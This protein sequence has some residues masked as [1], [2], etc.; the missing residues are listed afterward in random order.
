MNAELER[1]KTQYIFKVTHMLACLEV[2]AMYHNFLCC[3]NMSSKR[4]T[5]RPHGLLE[6]NAI[7]GVP[8]RL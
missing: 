5:V 6:S 3:S 4:P 2:R 8:L 1:M 7:T